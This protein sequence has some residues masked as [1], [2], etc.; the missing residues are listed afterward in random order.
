[1]YVYMFAG[2]YLYMLVVETFSGDN[3]RLRVYTVLGWGKR[4]TRIIIYHNSLHIMCLY[5][6][7]GANSIAI[8]LLKPTKDDVP[9]WQE[10]GCECLKCVLRKPKLRQASGSLC[11]S[12][13]H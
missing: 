1:M 13:F 4:R 5:I 2:L 11:F 10:G 12:K 3:I 9:L 6:S 8:S 7:M